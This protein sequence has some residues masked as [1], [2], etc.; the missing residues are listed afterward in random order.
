MTEISIVPAVAGLAFVAFLMTTSGSAP[1]RQRVWLLPAAASLTFL[2]V[3]LRAV[4]AEGPL[5]F[6][7]E[8]TRN[9]WGNQI[10]LDLLLSASIGWFFIA[11]QA[12]ALGMRLLPWSFLIICTGSIGFL[13]FAAKVLYLR[14][15]LAGSVRNAEPASAGSCEIL[16]LERAH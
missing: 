12:K 10:W 2:L 1:V 4:I 14:E 9:L 15:H 16:G 6:W 11:P 8:H 13:A 5:G 7:P 3:T